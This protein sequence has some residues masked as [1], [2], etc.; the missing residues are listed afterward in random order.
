LNGGSEDRT[1]G[2]S[3]GGKLEQMDAKYT[4]VSFSELPKN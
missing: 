1:C 4:A 2:V 3:G